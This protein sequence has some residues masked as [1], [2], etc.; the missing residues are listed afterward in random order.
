[1]VWP[2]LA[3]GLVDL[4]GGAGPVLNF[5]AHPW[6]GRVR[7]SWKKRVWIVDLFGYENG[8]GDA[9]LRVA[10]GYSSRGARAPMTPRSE[11]PKRILMVSPES[12]FVSGGGGIGTYLRH[13]VR[14]HLAAGHKVHVLTWLTSRDATMGR[15][16]PPATLAP[17]LPSDVTVLH[18][19]NAEILSANP[20]GIR[21]KNISDLLFPHIARLELEFKPDIIEGSDHRFPLHTYLQ[22]RLCG[23]HASNVPIVTFNHG[24]LKDIY[25]ASALKPSDTAKREMVCEQQVVAWADHVFA[26]SQAALANVTGLRGGARGSR[27]VRAP[28]AADTWAKNPQFDASSFIYFGRVAIAKGVDIFAGMM[29]AVGEAWPITHITFLGRRERTPFRCADMR[30]YI[31][32]RLHPDLLPLVR[33]KDSL[34]H[35]SALA[36]VACHDFFANFSRSETFSYTTLEALSR[37]VI[38]LV[39]SDSPMAEFFPPHLRQKGTFRDRP[40]RAEQI[41]EV[42]N[43]WRHNYATSLAALQDFA[44][45]VTRPDTYAAAYAD[46]ERLVSRATGAAP[47]FLGH[48]V[49]VLICTHDDADLAE[50]AIASIESQT[51]KV[52][53][54]VVLDDGSSNSEM[55][56]RLDRLAGEGRIRLIRRRNMG[57]VAGRNLLV[58]SAV[59]DLVVFLDADDRLDPTYIEKTLKAMNTAPDD[60]GAVLTRRRNFGLNQHES[61]CFLLGSPLHYIFNDLRMT[62]L[63]KRSILLKLS[64]DPL[65]RNGEADDWWFWLRFTAEGCKAVQVPEPLFQYRQTGASMSLPWS[66]GQGALTVGRVCEVLREAAAAGRLDVG[67][68]VQVAEEAIAFAYKRTWECDSLRS[69]QAGRLVA[70]LTPSYARRAHVRA[71]VASLLGDHNT[72]RLVNLGRRIISNYPLAGILA[73]QCLTL[74][75]L[76]RPDDTSS[77]LLRS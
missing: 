15:R 19:T 17:L 52:R 67:Q 34:P 73:K 71:R 12:Y 65:M 66:E 1:M 63:I 20:L 74:C 60:L 31:K 38:P 18:I 55:C 45:E 25:P 33:F 29:T 10:S 26:P 61:T 40:H 49:S 70:A 46:I 2:Y 58:E 75:R 8:L 56:E 5:M 44:R 72:T 69:Q 36:E 53:E 27:L 68:V 21:D 7:V 30:A 43:F 11:E 50:E 28:F 42:L 48:D 6:S 59:T 57:L 64:F 14:A 23:A 77:G 37:G 4:P 35:D 13:A 76:N 41:A 24:L 9:R 51:T 47:R 22:Q 39:M 54:I 16:I 3:D 62:A 32:Q